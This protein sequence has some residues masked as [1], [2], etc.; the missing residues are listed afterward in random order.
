MID[1]GIK[2]F[3]A[4]NGQID[5]AVIFRWYF[6]LR[7]DANMRGVP[8]QSYLDLGRQLKISSGTA[9][10]AGTTELFATGRT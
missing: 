5:I 3:V 7:S 6:G 8:D 10:F 4:I 2:K 9:P 1:A